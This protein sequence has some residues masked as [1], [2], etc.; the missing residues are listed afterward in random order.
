[1]PRVSSSLPSSSSI[2][3]H[4]MPLSKTDDSDLSEGS[5]LRF[6]MLTMGRWPRASFTVFVECQI[7]ASKERTGYC[8]IVRHTSDICPVRG[9]ADAF[10]KELIDTA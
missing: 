5:R 1:M 7:S 10:L 8:A 4:R 6:E 9:S 3:H 2:A